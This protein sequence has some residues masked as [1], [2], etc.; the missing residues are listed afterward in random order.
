M[1]KVRLSL[2]CSQE[3]KYFVISDDTPEYLDVVATD[4]AG[5]WKLRTPKLVLSIISSREYYRPWNK[6]QD[7]EDF[8]DGLM[9]VNMKLIC[10]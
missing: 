3:A 5:N 2:F 7:E 4:M 6:L 8:E 9:M 1:Y 10:L